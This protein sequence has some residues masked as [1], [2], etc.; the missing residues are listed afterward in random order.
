MNVRVHIVRTKTK[1][2]TMLPNALLRD[3]RMRPKARGVLVTLL[4]HDDGWI[5]SAHA[6]LRLESKTGREAITTALNELRELGYVEDTYERDSAGKV[7]RTL[8]VYDVS[9][10]HGETVPRVS[11]ATVKPSNEVETR[12]DVE[13]QEP[14]PE[15]KAPKATT[16]P[17]D[18]QVYLA[19]RITDAWGTKSGKLTLP[20]LQ[21]LN[22]RYGIDAVSSALGLLRQF[23]PSEAVRSP[24]AY[25]EEICKQGVSA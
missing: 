7:R 3:E 12:L 18:R 15:P 6:V 25:V 16:R 24:Y 8:T 4:S 10:A 11:G 20:A 23:D 14:E 22:S 1:G 17:T 5:G 2:F 21:R 9:P 19:E 13:P